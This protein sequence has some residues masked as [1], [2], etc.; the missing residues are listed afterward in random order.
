[1]EPSVEKAIIL[2][3][4]WYYIERLRFFICRIGSIL[5]DVVWV[6]DAAPF[7][8]QTSAKYKNMLD[9]LIHQP[10]GVRYA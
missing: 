2:W 1:M 10:L 3:K 5:S 4:I 8:C 7:L 9:R 6:R